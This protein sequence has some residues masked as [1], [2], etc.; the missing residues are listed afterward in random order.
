M[1]FGIKKIQEFD[2][3]IHKDSKNLQREWD[4]YKWK[5][6][7]STGDYLR[8]S[9]GNKVPEDKYNHGI[10]AVRYVLSYFYAE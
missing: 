7:M 6:N 1:V 4:L 3:H 8:N 9:K 2:V 10:D 5:K